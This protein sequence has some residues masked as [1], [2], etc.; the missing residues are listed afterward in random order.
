MYYECR[1]IIKKLY[2]AIVVNQD[3]ESARSSAKAC[4]DAG[5]TPHD[6]LRK[7][8]EAMRE[9][10]VLFDRGE[11]FL[12][13]IVFAADAMKAVA[14]VILPKMPERPKKLGKV[15][16]GTV[17]GDVHDVGKGI[18]AVMMDAAGFDV[19]DLGRDVPIASFIE[20]A[21]ELKPDIVGCS[22][23]MT[24][25]RVGQKLVID[26]LKEIGMRDKVKVMVGGGATTGV[27]AEQIGADAWGEDGP[28]AVAK[29]KKLLRVE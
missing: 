6:V 17:E 25:T 23:L 1:A 11:L 8:T 19:V 29:A 20:K 5:V 3:A 18:V 7:A 21:K 27:W 2:D 12:P 24:V 13:H 14:E 9:V 15:I 22:A 16:I 10:G 28:D 26:G 4:L